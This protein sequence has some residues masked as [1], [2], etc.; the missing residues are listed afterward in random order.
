MEEKTNRDSLVAFRGSQ[1]LVKGVRKDFGCI[2]DD[3]KIKTWMLIYKSKV[4]EVNKKWH[5]ICNCILLYNLIGTQCATV[6]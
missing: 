2:W 3:D 6:P 4:G 5:N 1:T